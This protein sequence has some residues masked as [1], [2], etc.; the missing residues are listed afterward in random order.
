MHGSVLAPENN[1]R[2]KKETR[3]TN[4][5]IKID[6]GRD[7]KEQIDVDEKQTIHQQLVAAALWLRMGPMATALLTGPVAAALRQRMGTVAAARRRRM[8]VVAA[9]SEGEPRDWIGEE[10]DDGAG[11]KG[12]RSSAAMD[13]TN[14]LYVYR[15]SVFRILIANRISEI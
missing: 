5:Q 1:K 9:A 14:I 6:V 15:V 2:E 7:G 13:P 11:S 3:K 4:N 12:R 8:G 10:S